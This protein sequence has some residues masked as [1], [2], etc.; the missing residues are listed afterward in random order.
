MIISDSK[1]IKEIQEEFNN[2][3][4]YLKIE[5]YKVA[6]NEKEGSPNSV[7]WNINEPIRRIRYN[8]NSG[9]MSING[10]LKVSTLENEF[11]EKYGL[12]VQVFY[13]S[14]DVWLQTISAN[15]D[16]LTTLNER[17]LEFE[18]FQKSKENS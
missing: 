11:E 17:S 12:H 16:S 6:H 10:H 13:K 7:K 4:P 9:D 14:G 3:F 1:T 2:K 5:F 18:E 8:H 15:D